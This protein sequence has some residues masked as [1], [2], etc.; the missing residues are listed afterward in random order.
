MKN[1]FAKPE[2]IIDINGDPEAKKY[3]Q[4]FSSLEYPVFINPS[5]VKGHI[6]FIAPEGKI[7]NHKGIILSLFGDYRDQE[8]RSVHRFFVRK[9]TLQP[10]GSLTNSYETDFSFDS[11]KIPTATYYGTSMNAIFGIEATVNYTFSK[12][13]KEEQFIVLF[14]KTTP[15]PVP[16]HNEIGMRNVLHIEFVF[17]KSA[18]DCQECVSASA[19]F[20]LVKIRI[21]ELY[22]EIFRFESFNSNYL[23]FE[24]KTI[25][26]SYQF[27][28]GPPVRGDHVPI[29]LFLSDAKIWPYGNFAGSDLKVEYYLRTH[30]VD[31]NGKSYYK[32]LKIKIDRFQQE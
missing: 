11:L 7:V 4:K 13:V 16:I 10:E 19:F 27:L 17:P 5:T 2:I 31:E 23:N 15:Q 28:D 1:L 8:N 20:I 6:T 18:Y 21:V 26:K 22:I 25:I 32:R 24:K 12:T 14:Y 9:Q 3:L 29:R 30:I